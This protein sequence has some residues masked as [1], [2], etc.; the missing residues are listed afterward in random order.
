[1]LEEGTLNEGPSEVAEKVLSPLFKVMAFI[2]ANKIPFSTSFPIQ[3][4]HITAHS[5]GIHLISFYRS[6][7]CPR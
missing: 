4:I 6:L 2:K 3:S 1:M 7:T 5:M